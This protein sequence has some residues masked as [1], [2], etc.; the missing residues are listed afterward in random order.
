[1]TTTSRYSRDYPKRSSIR[2]LLEYDWFAKHDTAP[3]EAFKPVFD[4][5]MQL[6][7]P[8][9]PYDRKLRMLRPL[10]T[11]CIA[12]S[13]CELGL[14][15]A[16]RDGESRDPHVLSSMTPTRFM[17]VGQNPGWNEIKQGQPFVGAAGNNFNQEIA[18]YGLSRSDFYICNTV[19]C[20]TDSN[21]KPTERQKERC[22]PFL[23]MEINIIKPLLVITLGETAFSQFCPESKY[24]DCLKKITKSARYGV[25]VFA[26]YH[27]SPLNFRE[28]SRKEAFEDQI[29]VMAKLVL[30][31]REKN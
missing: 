18:K 20:Y 11:T 15:E 19:R 10:S 13:M 26:I 5:I 25:S 30:A 24:G 3:K 2:E 31:L 9:T 22:S 7:K 8:E 27:P 16:V 23:Q 12:C 14:K 29:R 17:I 21:A 6:T 4:S 28:A 1:M